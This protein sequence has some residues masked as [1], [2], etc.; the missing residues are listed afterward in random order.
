QDLHGHGLYSTPEMIAIEK[1][2]LKTAQSLA[3]RHWA[4][5]DEQMIND[6]CRRRGLSDEQR[7]AALAATDQR[8]LAIVEGAAGSGKT[9][10]LKVVVDA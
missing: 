9:T 8:A 10:T 2:L 7:Q 3:Q 6:E 4:A 1:S 5:I